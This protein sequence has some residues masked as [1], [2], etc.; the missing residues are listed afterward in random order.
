M[1]QY[2]IKPTSKKSVAEIQ[3]FFKEINGVKVWVNYEETWRWGSFLLGV[4]DTEEEIKS[5][6]EDQGCDTMEELLEMYDAETLEDIMLPDPDDDHIMLT[7]DYGY[8]FELV[9]TWD[10]CGS[11]FTAR[12]EGNV[13]TE[14][15]LEEI[16]NEFEEGWYEDSYEYA[17]LNDWE[18]KYCDYE[19]YG[20]V[21]I[22]EFTDYESARI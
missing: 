20:G 5:Y 16:A 3:S 15:Q 2:V 21:T 6:L 1:K 22:E 11:W 17:E 7:E 19:I 18:E 4:P 12:C 14:E 8:D 13:L 9:E 10:G